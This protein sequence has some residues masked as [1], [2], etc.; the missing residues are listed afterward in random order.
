MKPIEE[1]ECIMKG[2]NRLR[3]K[4][5]HLCQMHWKNR[6]KKPKYTYKEF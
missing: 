2:C 4:G 1:E 6:R 3:R 5:K